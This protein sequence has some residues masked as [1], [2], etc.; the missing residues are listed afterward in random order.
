MNRERTLELPFYL[1]NN[2]A[3]ISLGPL[4]PKKYCTYSCP[5]CYVHS[6]F[7]KYVNLDLEDIKSWLTNNKGKYDIIYISG[8]TDSFAK[9]RTQKALD[10]LESLIA[11]NVDVLFTTRYVFNEDELLRIKKIN[12]QLSRKGR[13][14]FGCVSI[15]QLSFNHLE[16]KPIKPPLERIKQLKRFK[17]LGL[18]SVLAMRPFLPIV[19]KEE[20]SEIINLSIGSFDILLGESWYADKD[21]VLEKQVFKTQPNYKIEFK[22]SPMDFDN[23][24][25]IWK[26]WEGEEIRKFVCKKSEEMGFPFFMRSRP[27]IEWYRNKKRN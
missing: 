14:L 24:Q 9:P 8:D 25:N 7:L 26:V 12:E 6:G 22:E 18:C 19:P 20:Y 21:G 5:F 3:M 11:F 27:A 15:A 16:P 1:G 23:N 17:E 4:S 10:L 13:I 2:R